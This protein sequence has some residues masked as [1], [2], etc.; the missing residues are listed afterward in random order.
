MHWRISTLSLSLTHSLTHSR[1]IST[2]SHTCSLTLSLSL[3]P[4]PL[5]L[6]GL[7]G[8]TALS[9]CRSRPTPQPH[10]ASGPGQDR[11]LD[12]CARA[13]R[14]NGAVGLRSRSRRFSP[15]AAAPAGPSRRLQ[16]SPAAARCGGRRERCG[17]MR[18]RWQLS[19]RRSA[20]CGTDGAA[21]LCRDLAPGAAARRTGC[22]S[23]LGG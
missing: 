22:A 10:E 12:E 23:R 18:A 21:G 13:P 16:P 6:F 2:L 8:L 20:C 9:L 1:R 11:L 3:P 7:S 15:S 5:P 19:T 17:D 14:I 4:P